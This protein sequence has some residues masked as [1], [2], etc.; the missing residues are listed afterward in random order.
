MP[1]WVGGMCWGGCPWAVQGALS[2]VL[3][4][5]RAAWLL[6]VAAGSLG[7]QAASGFFVSPW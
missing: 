6:L 1:E 7:M 2:W 5:D 3:P 4:Q